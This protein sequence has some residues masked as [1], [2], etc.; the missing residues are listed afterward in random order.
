MDIKH[1]LHKDGKLLEIPPMKEL[2]EVLTTKFEEQEEKIE[3]LKEENKKLKEGVW[4]KEE[5]AALENQW[6]VM[7]EEWAR[8]FPLTEAEED[9]IINWKKRHIEQE[10]NGKLSRTAIGGQFTYAF[11]PTSIGIAG[12][13]TCTCGAGYVFRDLD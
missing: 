4:E 1:Y 11:T 7:K 10:H 13:V 9:N 3:A 12:K 6:K 5:V 2:C 8:G